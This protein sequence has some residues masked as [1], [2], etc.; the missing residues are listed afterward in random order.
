MSLLPPT[1][2]PAQAQLFLNPRRRRGAYGPRERAVMDEPGFAAARAAITAWP[3]Y[4]PTPLV[5]L[6]GLSAALGVARVHLKD[7][8]GRFGLRSFKALGGAY[9]VERQM[10]LHGPGITVTCATDGNHGRSVA[11]AAQRFHCRCVIFVHGGVSEGRRAAIV[12]L[13]AEVRV[14]RGNYDDS[15]RAAAQAAS[16]EGWLVVSDTSYEGYE[17]IPRRVMQGYGVIA[18]EAIRQLPPCASPTHIFAQA[19]VGGMAAAVLATFWHHFGAARPKFIVVEPECADSHLRS[20][21]SGRLVAI[22][23]QL[24]TIMA[25]LSCG[26]VSPLAWRV[27][28]GGADAFAAIADQAAVESMRLLARP[29]RGDPPIVAG[30]SAVAGLAALRGAMADPDAAAQLG[31]GQ[32]SLVLLW[33]TEGATDR[34]VYERLVG[35]RAREAA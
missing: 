27:L 11:W 18:I 6:P 13:G 5:A 34:V 8:S 19:G 17:R 25:G 3:G 30:E 22:E 28:E 33:G 2:R 10:A 9:A 35:S 29:P 24:D 20:A 31:L 12:S 16:R 14:V 21:Q 23:G 4:A 1:C 7:E 32:G 15:V 26:E